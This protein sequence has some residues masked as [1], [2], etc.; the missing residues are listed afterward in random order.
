MSG[1]P[2]FNPRLQHGAFGLGF[3]GAHGPVP[4]SR[5]VA[6]HLSCLLMLLGFLPMHSGSQQCVN[7]ASLDFAGI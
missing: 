6:E 5:T 2:D 4:G 1:C 7:V 3:A